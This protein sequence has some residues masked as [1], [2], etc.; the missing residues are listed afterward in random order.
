M[1]GIFIEA[2][3][4]ASHDDAVMCG[5]DDLPSFGFSVLRLLR[6]LPFSRCIDIFGVCIVKL[7]LELHRF[8][9]IYYPLHPISTVIK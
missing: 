8:W 2:F 1:T 4:I 9:S 6:Y 7:E 3:K 5:L